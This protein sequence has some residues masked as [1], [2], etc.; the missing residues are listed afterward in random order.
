MVIGVLKNNNFDALRL[1][2]AWSVLFSHQFPVTGTTAPDWMNVAMVGGAAVMTFFV[3]SGYLVTL[4]WWNQPQFF[5]FAAKRSLRIWPALIV[6]VLLCMFILGASFTRL[7][8][9]AYLQQT[10]TW[11]YLR[12]I[13]L[14]IQY[15]LPGV[16]SNH[17]IANAVNGSLWTI[18][19]EVTCYAVLAIA[20]LVG[21]LKSRK[22]WA[23]LCAAYLTWFLS[24][25]TMDLTGSMHH[26]WEFPAYFAFGSLIAAPMPARPPRWQFGKPGKQSD[27]AA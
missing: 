5:A 1:A 10:G 12:N 21:L 16:F 14:D 2:A 7:P 3:I 27:V 22:V 9:D 20:G 8:S 26:A 6:V 17:P 11:A 4:S 25:M 18:P 23:F 24:S 13:A 19:I 15:T